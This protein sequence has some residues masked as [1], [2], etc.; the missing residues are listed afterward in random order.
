MSSVP[1]P[2]RF[3]HA[4]VIGP[5]F[6][7]AI[8]RAQS[9]AELVALTRMFPCCKC[10]G[11]FRLHEATLSGSSKPLTMSEALTFWESDR[12]G[13]TLLERSVR[14][15]AHVNAALGRTATLPTLETVQLRV[16]LMPLTEQ[17]VN[18][19][20]L[21]A[22]AS[23]CRGDNAYDSRAREVCDTDRASLPVRCNSAALLYCDRVQAL[24]SYVLMKRSFCKVAERLLNVTES[25]R[26]SDV[27][28][29]VTA[30]ASAAARSELS[31]PLM[32]ILQHRCAHDA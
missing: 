27:M 30:M 29:L 6:W 9:A 3:L 31:A 1:D 13:A 4:D 16:Q 22:L 11:H 20:I 17:V 26:D 10:R 19:A 18:V 8:H 12:M 23:L 15:H 24:K 14:L 2:D 25:A 7:D 21:S 28:A 5:V 32:Q